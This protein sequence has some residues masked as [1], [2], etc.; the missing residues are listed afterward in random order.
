MARYYTLYLPSDICEWHYGND[1]SGKPFVKAPGCMLTRSS[2]EQGDT[3]YGIN[4]VA[5]TLFLVGRMR[6]ARILSSYDE[7][8]TELGAEAWEMPEYL[9]AEE[10]SA[11]AMYFSRQL[12]WEI[13]SELRLLRGD[14]SEFSLPRNSEDMLDSRM[15]REVR[16]L[17]P[18]SA[19]LLD[20]FLEEDFAELVEEGDFE[21]LEEADSPMYEMDED[22]DDDDDS[23]LTVEEL[24]AIAMDFDNPEQL[25]EVMD[26]ANAI[27]IEYFQSEGYRVV[28]PDDS[29]S[30][31]DFR[32]TKDD[33]E[34]H[35][36]VFGTP[37]EEVRFLMADAD[38]EAATEDDNAV[39]CIVTQPG[40]DD[41]ELSVF[42][43]DTLLDD[44][45]YRPLQWGFWY[46][47]IGEGEEEEENAGF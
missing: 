47:E 46:T 29:D 44:F 25:S 28:S 5:G 18:A 23:D 33:E 39:I 34:Y 37:Q 43:P 14:G 31:Y 32:C 26:A 20:S 30:Y 2:I 13:S 10:G 6:V 22:D 7:V 4:V 38:L 42:D 12:P 1:D 8:R 41:A 19:E 11:T 45:R 17:T 36:L 9:L 24:T 21:D 40:S 3:V 27:V 35:V 16:E 15:L